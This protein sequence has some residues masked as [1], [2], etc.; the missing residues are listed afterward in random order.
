MSIKQLPA[1]GDSN[2]GTTLNNYITQT[3]DNTNGGGLNNFTQFSQRPTNL[4]VDDQG[5]TYLYTQTGNIHQWT[6]TVWKV[7]N[8]SII[9]VKDYGAVGDGVEDDRNV[10]FN[11]INLTKNNPKI[12]TVYVPDGIY[13]TSTA[14][15]FVDLTGLKFIGESENKT[16][17][18]NS[19]AGTSTFN[20]YNSTH[21]I[22]Q[23]IS[24]ISNANY[25][26]VF[27]GCDNCVVS[28]SN[29]NLQATIDTGIYINSSCNSCIEKCNFYS[30]GKKTGT[31]IY[32]TD[33]CSKWYI[34]NNNFRYLA[35]GILAKNS[36]IVDDNYFDGGF[37]TGV[38]DFTGT[39]TYTSNS[40]SNALAG[41]SGLDSNAF[42]VRVLEMATSGNFVFGGTKIKD[43][44]KNFISMGLHAGDIV[45]TNNCFAII[46][47]IETTTIDVEE[48]LDKSSRLPTTANSEFSY[49]IYR[50]YIG[51]CINGSYNNSTI[52][53]SE[54]WSMNGQAVIPPNSSIYE[55]CKNKGN[56]QILCSMGDYGV[57]VTNNKIF[58]PYSDGVG[59]FANSFIVTNNYIYFTQDMGITIS[60]GSDTIVNKNAQGV[61]GNNLIEH[62]GSNGIYLGFSSGTIVNS[63]RI[64]D[65]SFCF[66]A[67]PGAEACGIFIEQ[68]KDCI[69]SDNL[70]NTKTSF[71]MNKGI[72]QQPNVS[73][74]NVNNNMVVTPLI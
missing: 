41:F 61:V 17:F 43:I 35:N 46:K 62:A 31:G 57:T 26:I 11:C 10:I 70:I 18:L 54:W 69:V 2:W 5:K 40:L 47:N 6:G 50:T 29:F 8:E 55:I 65:T 24:F 22:I 73:N 71:K 58:R 34:R 38:A 32:I 64:V 44:S 7:L 4:T 13:K 39:A 49:T 21:L 23:N 37:Y 28:N 72:H 9:N 12:D 59:M 14:I 36:C 42:I 20:I 63:N 48:W 66:L 60:P 45:Y 68:S 74:I 15:P 53:V 30:M 25:C 27:T 33:D 52:N 67:G 3:V 19:V 1:I 16:I 51:R 56:Y